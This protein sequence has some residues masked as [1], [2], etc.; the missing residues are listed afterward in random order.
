M[1]HEGKRD[2]LARV[3]AR[4][5]YWL[6]SRSVRCRLLFEDI[7]AR[8]LLSNA[9]GQYPRLLHSADP[10]YNPADL[11]RRTDE[12]KIAA[13]EYFV[14]ADRDFLLGKPFNDRMFFARR[15]F[16]LGVL[17]HWLRISPEDVVLELGAGSCW[18]SHQLNRF[19]CKTIAVDV[20][21]TALEI[22]RELFESDPH[23]NWAVEPEFLRFD[24]HRL[25]LEDG[26]VDKV[27]IYDAFH[28]VP[29]TKAVLREMARV[30]RDG[31]IIGMREPGRYH[32]L[33]EKSLAEAREFGVLENDVV[34]E[35]IERLGWECGLTRTTIVP[36]ALDES[37]EV[38][39]SELD[40]FMRARNLRALW[41]PLCTALVESNFILMYKGDSLPDTRR[42]RMLA[43]RI[44]PQAQ[45]DPLCVS[46]GQTCRLMVAIENTGDT[47]W[48]ADTA[49]QPGWT[50]LGI[51]LHAA[52]DAA[53]LIDGE[54]QRASL[55]SDVAPRDV[56]TV[57]VDLPALHSAGD[58]LL[59]FD[60]V[61]E[62]VAWF[63]DVNSPTARLGLRVVPVDA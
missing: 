20:S 33:A 30:V 2:W 49:G 61:A 24:G 32:A 4:S 13:E 25:P 36:L 45:S 56:V 52:D 46:T 23:T 57:Q 42:P 10:V 54:W 55:P 26:S 37:I 53:A 14:R 28:H 41:Q 59:V 62:G 34:V 44:V 22:G 29:N 35:E 17:F 15:L 47:L 63:A 11:V 3:I 40:G 21:G 39:A 50:R 48:L 8:L 7:G 16:D 9:Q 12:L 51:R 58:Y 6:S 60:L 5:C 38:R 31:G 43:A 1:I 18:L 27:I 19:G